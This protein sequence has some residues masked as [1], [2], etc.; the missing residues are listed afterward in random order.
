MRRKY[1]FES[2][3]DL[4]KP[5]ETVYDKIFHKHYIGLHPYVPFGDLPKDLQP[6]DLI[7]IH[8]EESF[9]S[10]N[11]SWDDHTIVTVKRPRLETDEEHKERLEKSKEYMDELRDLRYESYLNLKEEFEEPPKPII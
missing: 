9:Y 4:S 2:E 3:V 11:D 6:E 1:L 8:L 7:E 10:E 5:K